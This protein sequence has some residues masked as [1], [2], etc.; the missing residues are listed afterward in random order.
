M[1]PRTVRKHVISELDKR[2]NNGALVYPLEV[3]DELERASGEIAKKGSPDLPFAWAKKNEAAA[4]RYG[5]LLDGAKEVLKKVPKL[6]D[7][8]K[9]SVGGLDEADPHVIALAVRLKAEGHEVTIVTDDSV[10]KAKKMS[11]ADAAGVFQMPSVTMRTFLVSEG[12]WDGEEG[13]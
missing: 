10:T 5:H 1:V 7:P 3:V 6:I 4:T 13:T 12:I 2:V 8:D 9:V 11:L